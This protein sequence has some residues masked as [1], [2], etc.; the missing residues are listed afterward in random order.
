LR[1]LIVPSIL[2][3]QTKHVHIFG[4]VINFPVYNGIMFSI[5]WLPLNINATTFTKN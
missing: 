5:L 4:I 1:W 3:P 2:V